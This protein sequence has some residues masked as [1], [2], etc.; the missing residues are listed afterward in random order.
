MC[1]VSWGKC[2]RFISVSQQWHVFLVVHSKDH[3]LTVSRGQLSQNKLDW[4][5]EKSPPYLRDRIPMGGLGY[6]LTI[7][8]CSLGRVGRRRS[9]SSHRRR[10]RAAT[11]TSAVRARQR[12]AAGHLALMPAPTPP[13]LVGPSPKRARRRR[14]LPLCGSPNERN[15]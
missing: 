11:T 13:P 2:T 4:E 1:F 7:G 14:R 12:G 5:G 6:E 10:A 3:I 15:Q 9:G 8:K